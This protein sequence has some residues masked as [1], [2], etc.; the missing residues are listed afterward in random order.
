[1]PLT[2]LERG[3]GTSWVCTTEVPL[4]EAALA[5]LSSQAML[6]AQERPLFSVHSQLLLLLSQFWL[7]E[8]RED[9]VSL[10]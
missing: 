5:K 6:D 10:E 8:E 3:N 7:S 2:L 1:M 9:I 4:A